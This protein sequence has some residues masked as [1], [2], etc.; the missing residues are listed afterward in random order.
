MPFWYYLSRGEFVQRPLEPE[1]REANGQSEVEI[2]IEMNEIPPQRHRSP[3]LCRTN[4]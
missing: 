4:F 1:V 3:R 2:L